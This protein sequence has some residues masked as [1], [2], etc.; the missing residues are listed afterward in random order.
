MS[1]RWHEIAFTPAVRRIQ[2]QEG[3]RKAYANATEKGGPNDHLTS[4]ET[5]FIAARDGF[6]LA[7]VSGTGWPY[8][9]FRGG[10]AGLVR[11]LDEVT[12]GWADFRGNQQYV[13][14]G[15]ASSDDRVALFFMDYPNRRRLKLFGRL[16][17]VPAADD[18]ELASKLMVPEYKAVVQRAALVELEAFDWNCPQHIPQRFTLAEIDEALTPLRDRVAALEAEN[19]ELKLRLGTRR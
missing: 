16:R 19:A 1:H 9:Q 18:A 3:S 11:V 12:L 4:R 13:T 8:V 2:V 5:E 10:P 7:S 17:F 15:N 6:Y 14:A